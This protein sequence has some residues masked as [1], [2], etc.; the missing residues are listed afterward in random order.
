MAVSDL[1]KSYGSVE[2]VRGVTFKVRRGED[3][4]DRD[5]RGIPPANRRRGERARCGPRPANAR[6]APADR[7]VLQESELDWAHNPPRPRFRRALYSAPRETR[8]PTP[9]KQDKAQ[10]TRAV[11]LGYDPHPSV[12]SSSRGEES[13]LVVGFAGRLGCGPR[14]FSRGGDGHAGVAAMYPWVACRQLRPQA[15]WL[16]EANTSPA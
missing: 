2:A 7:L 5:P 10:P 4:H 12:L 14:L 16:H 3:H 8:T 11:S 1:R 9:H 6:L 15:R 13:E